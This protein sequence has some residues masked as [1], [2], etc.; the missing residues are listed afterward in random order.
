MTTRLA[1]IVFGALIV[2]CVGTGCGTG[3]SATPHVTVTTVPQGYAGGTF[4]RVLQYGGP[5]RARDGVQ[6]N[7][8]VHLRITDGSTLEA[9][10]NSV[11]VARFAIARGQTQRIWVDGNGCPD[12][13]L[14]A[15]SPLSQIYT[16]TCDIK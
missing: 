8:L 4:V 5:S 11:G 15:D 14:T 3:P 16:I 7:R 6:P 1:E 13:A 12:A 10:T 2:A 9:H